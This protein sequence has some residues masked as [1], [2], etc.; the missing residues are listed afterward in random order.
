[1]RP[2]SKTEARLPEISQAEHNVLRGLW[3]LKR[4]SLRE[5]HDAIS[6]ETGWAYTTT[7]TVLDRMA[8]KNLLKREKVHGLFVYSPAISKAA[9]IAR[10]VRYFASRIV[11]RDMGVVLG[12]F[13]ESEALSRKD[14]EELRALISE[15]DKQDAAGAAGEKSA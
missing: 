10:F 8:A 14:V 6:A 3:Q 4:A 7:K 12:L 5:V 15:L 9:G 11:E 13:R 2:E 1:M